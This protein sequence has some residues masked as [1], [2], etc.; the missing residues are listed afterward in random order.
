MGNE[1]GISYN[2]ATMKKLIKYSIVMMG[3]INITEM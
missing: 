3:I 2:Y 1:K